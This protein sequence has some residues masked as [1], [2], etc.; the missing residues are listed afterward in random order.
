MVSAFNADGTTL[1]DHNQLENF[2]SNTHRKPFHSVLLTAADKA[3]NLML[4]WYAK[5]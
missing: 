5:Y 3:Y 4:S 1:S 2:M